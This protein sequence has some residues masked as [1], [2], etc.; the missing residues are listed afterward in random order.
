MPSQGSSLHSSWFFSSPDKGCSLADVCQ[1]WPS[2][3][4][5]RRDLH[6]LILIFFLIIKHISNDFDNIGLDF[7]HI[8]SFRTHNTLSKVFPG[9]L[10]VKNSPAN[11][12][13]TQDLSSIPES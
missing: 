12:G 5:C 3:L 7:K 9:S 4:I 6:D 8:M 11:S 1:A 13:D 10:V 2:H